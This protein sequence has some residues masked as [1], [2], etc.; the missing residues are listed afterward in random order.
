MKT[1]ENKK[2]NIPGEIKKYSDLI[3]LCVKNPSQGG[4]DILEMRKRIKV[5]DIIEKGGKSFDFEDADFEC[6]KECVGNMRWV[7]PHKEIINFV[8]YISNNGKSNIPAKN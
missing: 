6:I 1:I 7:F 4:L 2:I 8:D 3:M 5:I